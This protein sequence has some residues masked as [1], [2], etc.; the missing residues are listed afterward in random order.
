ALVAVDES[1]LSLT[2]YQLENPVQAFY[3][4][5]GMETTDHHLR[6]SLRLAKADELARGYVIAFRQIQELP[7]SGRSVSNLYTLQ[8]GV[9]NATVSVT[10]SEVGTTNP[11]TMRQN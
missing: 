6:S 1:V 8:P 4:L 7:I 9:M 3:Q 11:I 10:S 2:N 5:R